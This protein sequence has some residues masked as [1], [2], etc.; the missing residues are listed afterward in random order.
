MNIEGIWK[1]EMLSPYGWV[2]LATAFL[3]NGRYYGGSADHYSIGHYEA[4][5]DTVKLNL[6]V[7]Q[8]GENRTVFG[9]N[10]MEALDIS[11]EA[12]VN[13]NGQIAGTA[14]L[15]DDDTYQLGVRMTR[16]GD[17]V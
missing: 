14:Y 7:T 4:E 8:H 11:V 15:P 10:N 16:L 2:N 5:G 13:G 12:S 9:L 6:H 1:V 3:M 17:V